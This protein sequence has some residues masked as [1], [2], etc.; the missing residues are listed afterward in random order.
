[1]RLTTVLTLGMK[2]LLDD[3]DQLVHSETIRM[4]SQGSLLSAPGD[5]RPLAIMIEIVPDLLRTFFG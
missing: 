3:I 4:L 1:M 5:G 2:A